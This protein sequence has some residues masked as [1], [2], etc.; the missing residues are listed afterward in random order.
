MQYRPEIDGLRA[1][2][3]LPVILF[4]AGTTLLSGGFVGV[5]VF[6]VISGYLIT[7]LLI[8]DLARGRFSLLDFYERRARRILP[9]L[10]FVIAACIPLAWLIL[11]PS[12]MINFA[13]SIVAVIFFCSNILFWRESGYF[14]ISSEMKPLLHTWSL[15]VE[16]QFYIFFPLFLVFVWKFGRRFTVVSLAAVLGLSFVLAH[17]AVDQKPSAA[18]YMLPF[19]AWELMVGSL[20]AVWLRDRSTPL[21]A[22]LAQWLS[23]LGLAMIIV[24]VFMYGEHTPFPGVN[25][26]APVAGTALIILC[27]QPGTLAYRLLSARSMVGVGLISYSAY[28]WHQPLLAFA[29]YYF[30]PAPPYALLMLLA[31]ASLVLAWLTWKYVEAPF[32]NRK[33]FSRQWIFGASGAVGALAV[34][35]GIGGM[36]TLGHMDRFSPEQARVLNQFVNTREYVIHRFDALKGQAFVDKPGLT[37]TLVIGDSYGQDFLNAIFEGNLSQGRSLSTHFVDAHCGNLFD[38]SGI[39]IQEHI[40]PNLRGYCRDR[41]ADPDFWER[42]KQADEIWLVSYWDQWMLPYLEQ[43]IGYLREQTEAKVFVVGRKDFG[44]RAVRE[45]SSSP[46][47]ESLLTEKTVP[48]RFVSVNK[49]MREMFDAQTYVDM[50]ELLCTSPVRCGN[51]TKEGLPISYDGEH[52]TP[53]GA[54]HVGE[55]IARRVQGNAVSVVSGKASR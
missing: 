24:P 48:D 38:E 19:R 55:L 20:A 9:A 54:R 6:F 44:Q 26:I 49:T 37:K 5:D 27:A 3:V 35:W 12:D 46:N 25:A 8:E 11:M 28:L 39:N 42:L 36:V 22:G 29:K 14:D 50:N 45:F 52:L 7:C 21:A 1:L 40:E 32:R 18:F 13:R 4:H 34:A 53:A 17:W 16:E 10:F 47:V 51:R 30:Y 41:F 31:A 2:A 15:S 43:S 23:L 33:R